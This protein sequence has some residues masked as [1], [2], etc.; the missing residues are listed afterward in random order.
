MFFN[1]TVIGVVLLMAFAVGRAP[2]WA[3]YVF[4]IIWTLGFVW[5]LYWLIVVLP[6]AK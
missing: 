3:Q 1:L 2:R 6:V 4:W 5:F